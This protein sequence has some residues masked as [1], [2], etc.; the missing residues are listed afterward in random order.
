MGLPVIVTRNAWTMPQE[1]WNTEWVQQ[2]GVGLVLKGFGDV[3]P[4]V[5][6]LVSELPAWR[7]RAAKVENRA[8]AQVPQVLADILARS[9]AA[10]DAH[11][12]ASSH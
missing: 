2:Q 6:Q 7:S 4:A 9:S 3:G 1:R 10:R 8:V 5:Q 11:R 12:L